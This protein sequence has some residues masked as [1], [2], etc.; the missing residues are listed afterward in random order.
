MGSWI[1]EKR[2]SRA[3]VCLKP[4]YKPKNPLFFITAE[5]PYSILSDRPTIICCFI[6]S[7]G[8]L[9]KLA[10]ISA[11]TEERKLER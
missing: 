9:T 8:F 3:K 6:I 11:V 7:K 5:K 4:I 2:I 1:P 10:T